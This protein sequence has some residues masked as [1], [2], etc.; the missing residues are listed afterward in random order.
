MQGIEV[1][2]AETQ[3]FDQ[4]EVPFADFFVSFFEI[5]RIHIADAQ[6]VAAGFIA[7]S[8]TDPA[9]GAADAR[10]P[11]GI[12]MRFVEQAV[13]GQ[14]KVCLAADEQAGAHIGTCCFH[15]AYFGYELYR[16][17]HYTIA[18]EVCNAGMENAA[19]Q[20]IQ[21]VFFAIEFEAVPGIW[22][23]L[24]TGNDIVARREVI[25]DFA[26]ALIAPLQA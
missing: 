6:P 12:F 9:E 13:R 14:D 7:V 8:R 23:A 3:E 21:Y 19:G 1:E 15:A 26:F 5:W 17:N 4:L 24:E 11:F 20:G 18:N 10:L 25:G 16:I 2:A 22:S